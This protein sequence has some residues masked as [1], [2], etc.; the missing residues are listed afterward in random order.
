MGLL[1]I[2]TICATAKNAFARESCNA[3][4]CCVTTWQRAK[5]AER[6]Y[7]NPIVAHRLSIDGGRRRRP[8]DGGIPAGRVV[9][10]R[11]PRHRIPRPCDLS[12]AAEALG[13]TRGAW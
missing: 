8:S 6:F 1:L 10:I 3:A 9:L 13:P 12:A 5:E 4:P 11:S 7:V 2:R